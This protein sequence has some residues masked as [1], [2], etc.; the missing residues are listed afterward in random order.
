M[1]RLTLITA[2]AFSLLLNVPTSAAPAARETWTSVRSKNFFLVG[3][4]SEREIKQVATRLEQF[5]DVFTRL[6]PR[7]NF[8]VPVPTTV[9]V[10]KSDSSY[11]PYKPLYQGKPANVAGYF[12]PGPDVNYITLT[13]EQADE[14]TYDVIFHEYVHLLVNNTLANTPLWFNEGLAEYYSTFDVTDD[15]KKAWIGK[16]K[17]YHLRLLRE[18]KLLPLQTLFAV[19]HNSS[20]YNERNKQSIFYAESWALVHYLLLGNNGEHAKQLTRF[21]DMLAGGGTRVEDAFQQAFQTDFATIEKELRQYIQRDTHP[22]VTAT[23]ERKLEFDAEM[24][25][26]PLSEAEAQSYLGDLLLHINRLDDAE[27]RLQQALALD[28]KLS[29]AE[30]SLGI[31][32][33]RQ[34]RF[35]EA[36]E[37]LQKAIEADSQNYLAHY[38]YAYALSRVA[39]NENEMVSRY[40]PEDVAAMRT[41]LRK[42]I[43]LKPS[44][45]ES[46]HLLAF[47]NLVANER[48]DEAVELIKSALKL[49]PGNQTYMLVLAQVYMQKRDFESARRILTPMSHSSSADPGL[50]AMAESLLQTITSMQ[51]AAA[52]YSSRRTEEK[53]S[54]SSPALKKRETVDAAVDAQSQNSS[55]AYDPSAALREALRPPQEGEKRVQGILV[56]IDCDAKGIVFTVRL[57]SGLIKVHTTKFEDMD[58]STYV[59][60]VSGDITCGARQQ[61]NVVVL[62]Y[63]PSAAGRSRYDGEGVALEFVPKGFTLEK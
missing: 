39:M 33:L 13:T 6:L 58:I 61:E 38:Y 5:R 16:T 34:R 29:I 32:R 1:K 12:Q 60:E 3:N 50:R 59:P 27:A 63:R 45:P 42:A 46:Y 2:L 4:A 9:V 37:A 18:Q 15:D 55:P 22:A 54:P 48:L 20:L 57:G 11:K 30:S 26:A 36:R 19:D 25:S 35:N 53:E 10:F 23:F 14:N 40:T 44:F 52:R 43:E 56:R 8:N 49:S 31:L 62:T 47:V 21:L 41:A 7:A 51:E 28:P 17:S 24:Q